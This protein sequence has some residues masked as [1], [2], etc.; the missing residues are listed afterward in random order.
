MRPLI[1]LAALTACT[2][3]E[4]I[5]GPDGEM[6]LSITCPRAISNCYEKAAEMCRGGYDVTDKTDES[7]DDVR[8]YSMFIKCK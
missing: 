7:V 5:P 8:R 6:Q 2:T 1:L 3:V 4:R